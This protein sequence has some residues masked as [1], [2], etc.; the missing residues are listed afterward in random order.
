M[1]SS[2]L[3]CLCILFIQYDNENVE[4]VLIS[5]HQAVSQSTQPVNNIIQQHIFENRTIFGEINALFIYKAF[6][7]TRVPRKYICLKYRQQGVSE[8]INN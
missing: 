1:C 4:N 8:P 6:G 2:L 7:V 3:S 5:K